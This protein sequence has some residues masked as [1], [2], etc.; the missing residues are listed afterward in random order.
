MVD[1][2]ISLI[3]SL[4]LSLLILSCSINKEAI[5]ESEILWDTWGIPHI[6]GKSKK[7][8]YK[9][10]G[11]AQMRNHGDLVLKLYGEA[12][13]RSNEYWKGSLERDVLLH[14]LGLIETSKKSYKNL[15]IADRQII[16]AFTEGIN[17]YAKKFPEN[18]D[19]KYTVVLPIN[20]EDVLAHVYRVGYFEF[21]IN[22]NLKDIQPWIPGSN[23]WA[24]NNSMTANNSSM[25]LANPHLPW[26]D[27][28]L[29]FEVNL[30]TNE[31]NLYGSTL[32]GV[33]T[34]SIGFNNFL[35]WT[36][37]VNTLDNVDLYELKTSEDKYEIDGEFREFKVDSLMVLKQEMDSLIEIP[38]IRKISE[39]GTIIKEEKDLAIAIKWPKNNGNMNMLCQ[40]RAMGEAQCLDEF[41]KALDINALPL[42]NVIYADRDGNILYHFGGNI[43][44]KNGDWKKWQSIVPTS[45][46]EDIWNEYYTTKELPFYINPSSNWIQNA[47]DPPFTS[48]IPSALRPEDFPS[49]IAPNN[50]AF[51]PQRSA[52]LI[53]SSGNLTLDEFIALKHDTKSQ[54]ALRIQDDFYLLKSQTDDSL[55]LA[56]LNLLTE[57]DGSF[58]R[59]SQEAIYFISLI[60]KLGYSE[61]FENRWSFDDP[62]KTPDGFKNPDKV[63][64]MIKLTAQEQLKSLGSLKVPF[65]DI[66]K[67]K[68]GEYIFPGNGGPGYL[69]IFRTMHYANGQDGKY[70]G[71][72]GDSYVC[73]IEF[74]EEIKAKAL[75]AYG[76]ATQKGNPHIGDQ[77]I[78]YAQ[79]KLR[80]VLL[81]RKQHEAHLELLEKMKN[82]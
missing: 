46:S 32:I 40:W 37:T 35:G 28:W 6:Y 15:S 60:N 64:E 43:P 3:F 66:F 14:Q 70:Y 81:T 8:A 65:G 74:G 82:M 31:N 19:E 39:F 30:I 36:H 42:F 69:G 75:I 41:K 78:L 21:L 33:P 57:W 47:N 12:R 16:S 52:T 50:M 56:A 2:K 5:P 49:H 26:K 68:A 22:R 13:G 7:D 54:L 18:L 24:I 63:L 17:S 58:D 80:K 55:T 72:H 48:T 11:W 51:R 27:F 38:V 34:I 76:N 23:A 9:M 10:L 62:L 77:L 44:K 79:K 29:F 59:N 71:Y 1:I 53:N 67:V 73:A 4:L 61:I 45:S 25:L 20:P